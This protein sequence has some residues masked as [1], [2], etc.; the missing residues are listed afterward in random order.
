MV[1]ILGNIFMGIAFLLIGPVPFINQA[2]ELSRT[3]GMTAMIGIGYGLVMVSTFGRAQGA[4]L[5]LG[6]KDDITTHLMI[7]C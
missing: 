6:F 7:S 1:S 3:W 4:A 2:P 5:N